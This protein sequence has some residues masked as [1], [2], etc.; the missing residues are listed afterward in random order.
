MKTESGMHMS[1][2]WVWNKSTQTMSPIQINTGQNVQKGGKG[3]HY[4]QV[5]GQ[6][7]VQG[8][9]GGDRGH[10]D[11][12]VRQGGHEVGQGGQEVGQG[13]HEAMLQNSCYNF[14][15]L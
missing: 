2:R 9:H 7:E 8:G 6:G 14:S 12:E 11:Q 4:G 5:E 15:T 10:G 1:T 13:G 3:E